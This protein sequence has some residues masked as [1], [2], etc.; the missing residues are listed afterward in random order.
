MLPDSTSQ[1]K[2][3]T[4]DGIA[5]PSTGGPCFPNATITAEDMLRWVAEFAPRDVA[6]RFDAAIE[7]AMKRTDR[8][9]DRGNLIGMMQ[10]CVDLMTLANASG[11]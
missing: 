11:F 1:T 7:A 9:Y 5:V 8:D 6:I 4:S 10:Q 2:N 3:F